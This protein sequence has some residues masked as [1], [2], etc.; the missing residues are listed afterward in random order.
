MTARARSSFGAIT[1]R[2]RPHCS[3]AFVVVGPSG[4]QAHTEPSC[5]YDPGAGQRQSPIT[6][7]EERADGPTDCDLAVYPTGRGAAR[8]RFF[9]LQQKAGSMF[10]SGAAEPTASV[11]ESG[12]GL[13]RTASTDSDVAG[14]AGVDLTG[15]TVPFIEDSEYLR[16]PDSRR[17]CSCAPCGLPGEIHLG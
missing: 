15:S 4:S 5:A 12:A 2:A 9:L 17:A 11:V 10:S 16:Y 7:G 3:L 14:R 6:L 1:A 8:S 13:A